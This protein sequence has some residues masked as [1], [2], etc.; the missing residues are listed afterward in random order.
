M[1]A[2]LRSAAGSTP[3]ILARSPTSRGAPHVAGCAALRYRHSMTLR[4]L[5]LVSAL[6]LLVV[7][8][9]GVAAA[10]TSIVA[11]FDIENQG[12]KIQKSALS[13]LSEF[14]ATSIA[15]T[16][17]Y[18]VVPRDAL[19]SRLRDQ[20]K[21][22][23]QQCFDASCQ[24]EIGKEL[25]ADHA[26]ATRVVRIGSNCV[27]TL[28]LFDLRTA[29]TSWA[30]TARGPCTEDG[31]LASIEEA[32]RLGAGKTPA[33]E[34]P[35]VKTEKTSAAVSPPSKPESPIPAVSGVC[36]TLAAHG[37]TPSADL[38]ALR[39]L[40]SSLTW[41]TDAYFDPKR[42][43]PR[44]M[45]RS[46]I[47]MVDQ[48][49]P[50]LTVETT[51][52]GARLKA[53]GQTHDVELSSV[54]ES[55]QIATA[56]RNALQWYA[57]TDRSLDRRALEYAA[58]QGMLSALDQHS[59][60]VTPAQNKEMKVA[61]KGSFG[62]LGMVVAM[63]EGKLVIQS[64]LDGTPAAGAHLV[65]GDVVM[66]IN[67]VTTDGLG[68]SKC[69]EMLRGSV[70]SQATLRIDRG[71][72]TFETVLTRETIRIKAVRSARIGQDVGYIK[73]NSISGTAFDEA[74]AARLAVSGARGLILDLR[75]NPGGLLAV[76]AKIADEF[77]DSGL[78]VETIGNSRDAKRAT[79]SKGDVLDMPIIVLTNQG[80]ASGAEILAGSLAQNH[81]AILM[82]TRTFGKGTV[83]SLHELHDGSSLKLTVA[84]YALEGGL[85]IEDTGLEPDIE[86]KAT[87][88]PASSPAEDPAVRLAAEMLRTAGAANREKMLTG[89]SGFANRPE[90]ERI[91]TRK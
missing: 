14:L 73:I 90:I 30:S 39:I 61:V 5:L 21:A 31:L 11:V 63:K 17:R 32:I 65:S 91:G 4:R 86:L 71:G 43:D 22:T 48:C 9:A 81:R 7:G 69:V 53:A 13:G 87:V 35:A 37:L 3:Q 19:R 51:A 40:N 72:R 20:K 46:A 75:N 74:H 36:R 66:A 52:T 8:D 89:L 6:T 42:V 28:K 64:P 83:Q 70:G 55:W 44:A 25:A 27:V 2:G 60:I 67:G 58:T 38:S 23:Y 84:S 56:V 78:I 33:A 45:L 15:A 50:G 85:T 79:A 29:A 57:A 77:L 59:Q 47:D 18:Q 41:V 76:A 34:A 24:I 12:V 10:G 49:A 26:L 62:G 68:L 54:R 88:L 80:T 16:G 82:G 1:I